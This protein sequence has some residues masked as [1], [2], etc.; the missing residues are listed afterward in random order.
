[1]TNFFYIYFN[2]L[3]DVDSS[4]L[5]ALHDVELCADDGGVGTVQ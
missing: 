5:D 4:Y 3:L 1:M 2:T